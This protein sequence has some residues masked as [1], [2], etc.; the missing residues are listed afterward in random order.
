MGLYT[1]KTYN[2]KSYDCDE[3]FGFNIAFAIKEF[4]QNTQGQILK[5]LEVRKWREWETLDL[6]VDSTEVEERR[7]KTKARLL[8]SDP[9]IFA[10]DQGKAIAKSKLCQPRYVLEATIP[11]DENRG[12]PRG[13]DFRAVII[14]WGFNNGQGGSDKARALTVYNNYL[15]VEAKFSHFVHD[16]SSTSK[17]SKWAV[18]LKRK[19]FILSTSFLAQICQDFKEEC[20]SSAVDEGRQINDVCKSMLSMSSKPIGVGFNVGSRFCK[21]GYS[22]ARPRMLK[23]K[24]EDLR[25]LSFAQFRDE[26]KYKEVECFS[27]M[28][29]VG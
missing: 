22:K 7:G 19:G 3:V 11:S 18:G 5:T 25:A 14:L 1:V 8:K 23:M 29:V 24:K 13:H 12:V 9:C 4:L 6:S 21:G 26:S 17:G 2:F 16:G 27:F 20:E 28:V 10:G 15:D